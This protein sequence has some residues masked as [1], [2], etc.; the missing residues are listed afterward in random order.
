MSMDEYR[1]TTSMITTI[2]PV[3]SQ[4]LLQT[5]ILLERDSVLS[6]ISGLWGRM[7]IKRMKNILWLLAIFAPQTDLV[8]DPVTGLLVVLWSFRRPYN[9]RI[10][11]FQS[12][13]IYLLWA[14]SSIG[15][16]LS[17]KPDIRQQ[18]CYI[19]PHAPQCR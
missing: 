6:Q 4:V 9:V 15:F 1:N 7:G 5:F 14:I 17:I 16:A 3:R 13:I 18:H 12:Y 8:C 19:I 2:H 10:P 11:L